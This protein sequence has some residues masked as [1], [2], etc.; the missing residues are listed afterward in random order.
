MP[1]N[2]IY[3][4]ESEIDFNTDIQENPVVVGQGQDVVYVDE[5]ELLE[6][7]TG[8]SGAAM[9]GVDRALSGFYEITGDEAKADL[10][11]AQSK[12]YKPSISSYK[13][14]SNP[15]DA[16]NYIAEN[17]A[18]GAVYAPLMVASL[19]VAVPTGVG[20]AALEAGAMYNEQAEDAK[21]VVRAITA[22]G[23]NVALERV[24]LG[25]FA[26]DSAIRNTLLNAVE[27][28][29][30]GAATHLAAEVIGQGKSFEESMATIDEAIVAGAATRIAMQPL[31]GR[32][33]SSVDYI[34]RPLEDRRATDIGPMEDTERRIRET[35]RDAEFLERNATLSGSSMEQSIARHT[36]IQMNDRNNTIM[37]AQELVNNGAR[38]QP[39][40]LDFDITVGEV[41]HIENGL[42]ANGNPVPDTVVTVPT[43]MNVAR[44]Y[45]KLNDT[46]MSRDRQSKWFEDKF[47]L[48]FIGSRL[49]GRSADYRTTQRARDRI[50]SQFN[51]DVINPFKDMIIDARIHNSVT[52]G[53]NPDMV[54]IAKEVSTYEDL[55]KSYVDGNGKLPDALAGQLNKLKVAGSNGQTFMDKVAQMKRVN[56][57]A[58]RMQDTTGQGEIGSVAVSGVEAL[59]TG[60]APIVSTTANL[61]G[62]GVV[63][64]LSHKTRSQIQ[65]VL[66]GNRKDGKKRAISEKDKEMLIEQLSG[67]E[68][69]LGRIGIDNSED[70]EEKYEDLTTI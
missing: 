49:T 41:V 59:A 54:A 8:I 48:P 53:T 68:A 62:Q 16:F 52:N 4:D 35:H 38:L 5:S 58:S 34:T 20:L 13:D 22:A 43:I 60:G 33:A 55:I 51:I 23:A 10:Y 36:G 7:S 3:V 27:E 56:Q 70:E 47:N 17:I 6:E 29:G 64:F 46:D 15:V 18:T 69:V 24:G 28:G 37:A 42:D 32:T 12:A 50:E 2:S 30:R 9:S 65:D 66:E 26:G 63:G 11:M 39:N 1:S 21:S 67:L 45:F 25:R 19:P 44:D 61:I 14:I 31:E 57:I 40:A